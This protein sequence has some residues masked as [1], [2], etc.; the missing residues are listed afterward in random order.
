MSNGKIYCASCADR[1]RIRPSVPTTDVLATPYQQRKHEKHTQPASSFP[2]QSVFDSTTTK[3]YRECI[4]E[5]FQKGA[6][7]L[8]GARTNLI[9]PPSTGSGLGTIHRW[10]VA[11]ARADTILVAHTT[12][13][14]KAHAMLEESSRYSRRT[15]AKCGGSV[16]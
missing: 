13:S 11:A 1:L 2:I 7:E 9:F 3:Y 6:V 8:D 16:F 12:S 15:C 4:E 10:G 5:A 14:G